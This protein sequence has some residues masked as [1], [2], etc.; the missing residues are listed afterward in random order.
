MQETTLD[1]QGQVRIGDADRQRVQD[2][3]RDAYGQGALTTD[4]LEE[5]LHAAVRARTRAEVEPLVRDLPPAASTATAPPEARGATTGRAVPG[6]AVGGLVALVAAAALA[7]GVSWADSVSVFGSTVVTPA[8]GEQL[9]VVSIFGSTEV[10]LP[11]GSLADNDAV[12][13][14]GSNECDDA[15]TGT[16]G[17]DDVEV[18]G[19]VLFG[20]LEIRSGAR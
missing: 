9:D 10:V 8:P 15:C 5:R 2:W 13:V 6:R 3:L 20:S 19:V 18:G 11:A 17:E 12:A 7:V 16:P 4:E 14:F 1:A